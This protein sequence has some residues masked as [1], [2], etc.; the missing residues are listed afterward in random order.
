MVSVLA[1]TSFAVQSFTANSSCKSCYYFDIPVSL[2]RIYDVL[3][4]LF[5]A[6]YIFSGVGTVATCLLPR[7]SDVSSVGCQYQNSFSLQ[8]K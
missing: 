3:C 1:V 7:Y 2:H 8:C 4:G 6:N 5:H